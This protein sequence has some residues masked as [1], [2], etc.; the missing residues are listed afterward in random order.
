[1]ALLAA[2]RHAAFKEID[3]FRNKLL[4]GAPVRINEELLDRLAS[5]AA[6]TGNERLYEALT[7]GREISVWGSH[8][9][10]TAPARA[11]STPPQN[12]ETLVERLREQFKKKVTFPE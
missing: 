5:A 10:S 11:D 8:V 12:E 2:A 6:L 7:R 1:M 4:S 3:E 9:S